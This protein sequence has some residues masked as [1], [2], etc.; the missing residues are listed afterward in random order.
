MAH[1]PLCWK[2]ATHFALS[3]PS[4]AGAEPARRAFTVWLLLLDPSMISRPLP[5]IPDE[6]TG[7]IVQRAI[8]RESPNLPGD[9][10]GMDWRRITMAL[11]RFKWLVLLMIALGLGAAVAATRVLH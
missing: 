9:H 11:L 3:R 7:T 5:A 10:R 2:R 1:V 8:P 6:P 4:C